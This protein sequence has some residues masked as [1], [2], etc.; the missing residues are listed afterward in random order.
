MISI[1]FQIFIFWY[2]FMRDIHNDIEP[3][4]C[5][6]IMNR[7]YHCSQFVHS[8]KEIRRACREKQRAVLNIHETKEMQFREQG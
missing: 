3:I 1:L 5:R 4:E 2:A 8:E 7:I 6:I